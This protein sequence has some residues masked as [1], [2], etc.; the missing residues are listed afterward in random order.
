MGLVSLVRS[1][2]WGMG[3]AYREEEITD[4]VRDVN[5]NAHISEV[6]AV[7]QSDQRQRHNMMS[8]QLFEI[9]PRLLQ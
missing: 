2:R 6:K 3:E 8:N 1:P 5:S 9:L 4:V 7:A